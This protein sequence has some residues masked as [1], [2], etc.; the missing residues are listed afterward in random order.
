MWL[1][2][3]SCLN[4]PPHLRKK[5]ENMIMVGIVHGPKTPEDL[6]PFLDVVSEELV[7]IWNGINIEGTNMYV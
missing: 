1:I 7:H 3:I 2:L 5:S 6:S 4:L